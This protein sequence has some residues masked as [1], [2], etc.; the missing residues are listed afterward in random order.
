[1]KPAIRR[2]LQIFTLALL[3]LAPAVQIWAVGA[4]TRWSPDELRWR[5]GPLAA[6]AVAALS[7]LLGDPPEA[8]VG[9]VV[10]GTWSIRVLGV[11][12]TDPLAALSLLASG[13]RPP[14]AFLLGAALVLAVHLLFGRI[15]CGAL[16]PY[17]ALSRAVSRLRRPLLRAGLALR[18]RLPPWVR[19]ALLAAVALA[20]AF[21]GSLALVTLPYL[22]L[23]RALHGL[24]FGGAAG[25]AGLVGALLLSDLLL[26]DHG[27]CRSLCPSGALQSLLG[28]WRVLRLV[29]RRDMPCDRGC[30][31]C[32]E[33]CWLGL[34]PRKSHPW[35]GLPSDCDGCGRCVRVCPTNRLATQLGQRRA[36]RAA[37]AAAAG[38]VISA[39]SGAGCSQPSPPL[40]QSTRVWSSPFEDRTDPG[41]DPRL[42]AQEWRLEGR[43]LSV[44]VAAEA[45][46]ALG[47]RIYLEESPG[48]PWRGPLEIAVCNDAGEARARFDGP[49]A[50]RSVPR[51]SLY[52]AQVAVQGAASL[53]FLDGPLAGVTL[54]LPEP[55][56]PDPRPALPVAAVLLAWAGGLGLRR[57]RGGEP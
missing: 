33:A 50:P 3:V 41:H 17:G 26:W 37:K 18:W 53:R 9:A 1:M 35:A 23:S 38:L 36:A 5:Y 44:S 11:E 49:S 16:C 8:A 30:H 24:F 7:G 40:I 27:V 2:A 14:V 6:P 13:V 25:V 42:A 51:P 57:G 31:A 55:G 46:G 21:G 29:P 10:G 43:A 15:F 28:R 4:T 22:G 56:S 39:A 47:I 19:L 45:S 52:E 34:D 20:P 48:E 54:P 12:L 32:A